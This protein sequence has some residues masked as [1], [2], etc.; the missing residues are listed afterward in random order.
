M[1]DGFSDLIQEIFAKLEF[2]NWM[3]ATAESCTGG[4]ISSAITNES[5]SSAYFDRGFVTYSNEAKMEML[6]VSHETL[7]QFGAVSEQ[8]AIEMVQGALKN[9][10][11]DIAVSVTGIAGPTGGTPEKPVGLVYI[12]CATADNASAKAYNF[13]DMS[14]E[15]VRENT[16]SEALKILLKTS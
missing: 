8:T 4:L 2:K 6:G 15:E 12:G 16:V 3:L 1:P 14:R 5:G 13:N 10:N 9:S 11:A 7:S